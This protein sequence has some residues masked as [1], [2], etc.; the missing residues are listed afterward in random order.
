MRSEF[1]AR[2]CRHWFVLHHTGVV[3]NFLKV[4]NHF[5]VPK[6]SQEWSDAWANGIEVYEVKT[7]APGSANW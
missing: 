1:E 5:I 2:Q 6:P 3:K 7:T 4:G